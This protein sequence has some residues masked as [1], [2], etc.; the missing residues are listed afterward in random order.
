[1]TCID[2]KLRSGRS[3]LTASSNLQEFA[4]MEKGAMEK[5]KPDP[6]ALLTRLH[7]FAWQGQ[8]LG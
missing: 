1:M 5:Q 6:A 7:R 2:E 4:D 8:G 3:H